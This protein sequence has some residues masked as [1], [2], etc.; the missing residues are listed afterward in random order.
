MSKDWVDDAATTEFAESPPAAVERGVTL[1]AAPETAVAG[2]VCLQ[3]GI[4]SAANPTCIVATRV[5]PER[6]EAYVSERAP[7]RPALGFVDATPHRPTPAVKEEVQA[8]EDIPSAGDLLQLTTAVEDVRDAIAPDDQPTNIVVPVFD[9][10][11]GGA[12][13]KRVVRVLS[14]IA[15]ATDDEGRVVIGLDYTAGSQETL[16]ELKD[17][18]DTMLW[19]ERNP[20]GNVTLDFEPLRP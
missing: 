5:P 19:A 2:D 17:H 20:A 14:H 10:L 11:L 3:I 1:V 4:G 15:E 12:P 18:S 16:Q 6:M 13:T 7:T 8:I 9:S